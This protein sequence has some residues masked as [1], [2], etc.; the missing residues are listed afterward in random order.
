MNYHHDYT[1]NITDIITIAENCFRS[2]FNN[3]HIK[4]MS[5]L[6]AIEKLVG[7]TVYGTK[8]A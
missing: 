5:N 6:Q 3:M 2:C 1:D 8:N 7:K 4:R